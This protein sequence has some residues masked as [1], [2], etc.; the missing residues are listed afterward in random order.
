M[1][2]P[3]ISTNAVEARY[4]FEYFDT[5]H[6]AMEGTAWSGL[7]NI[8]ARLSGSDTAKHTIVIKDAQFKMALTNDGIHKKIV[9]GSIGNIGTH[10]NSYTTTDID[11]AFVDSET[12]LTSVVT[13]P[14]K[15]HLYRRQI[16]PG[17]YEEISVQNLKMTYFIFENY[18]TVGD[19]V[20]D[21][22]LI[23][24]DRTI[25]QNY[26]MSDREILYSRSLHFV[27]NSLIVTKV[28]WY[29]TGVFKAILIIAAIAMAI[30]DG[31]ATLG[32]VLGL[33]GTAAIVA[34]IVIHLIVG[35]LI[36]VAFKYFV[37]LVGE[38]VA[39][40]I[41]VIALIY[42]GYQ[43]VQAGGLAG[44]P[45]AQALLEISTG[46]HQAAMNAR[47][48]SLNNEGEAFQLFVEDETERLETS[49]QLL[50]NNN[51]LSPFVIF[52][53]SPEDFY[54]RTVHSGNIGI[55]GITAISSYV[56]IALTL[57]KL[58]DTLGDTAYVA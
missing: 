38:E 55:L 32:A 36:A 25:S 7:T 15:V 5:L 17:L 23:P 31:G 51:F 20:D 58:N 21:I 57:P 53:E 24:I 56:D 54:N 49:K 16:A 44:A 8:S 6:A 26:S 27:F 9:A 33:T 1:A 50:E 42:G 3:A 41:A 13:M 35:Q 10:N 12:G 4:L 37:K 45:W 30:Y 39:T 11:V 19:E 28:K 18:T 52:G 46:L 2:V 40:V 47:M 29:Q 14:I 43:I 48:E 22:L 34:T